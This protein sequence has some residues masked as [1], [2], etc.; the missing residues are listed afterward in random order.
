MTTDAT[1]VGRS[2]LIVLVGTGV[3]MLGF[4]LL[5]VV[6]AQALSR[7][8]FGAIILMLSLLDIA[9]IGC[10]FGLN[11]GLVKH[12]PAT[13]RGDHEQN[14]Y[15]TISFGIVGIT[16]ILLAG[17]GILFLEQ[18]RE[19]AFAGSVSSEFIILTL[20]ALP[21]Y[22]LIK[23]SAG[24]LQGYQESTLYTLVSKIALSGGRLIAAVGA[25]LL[26]GSG[27]AVV[28]GIL[29]AYVVT[30]AFGLALILWTGWRPE[31]DSD[32]AI[33]SF[34]SFS[35]PLLL[36]SSLYILLTTADKVMIGYFTSATATVGQYEVVVTIASLL[37]VFHSSFSF[38]LFPRIS[39]LVSNGRSNE[40]PSL[41]NQATRWI[42]IFT[43]PL[44]SVIL[45][46]PGVFV[47]LF[48]DEYTLGSL[49]MPIVILAGAKLVDSVLGPN[50]Q[51]LLGFGKS[52][53]IFIYNSI[54][55]GL[56]VI[57]NIV[58]IPRYGVI[59]AA[60]SSL[61][62]YI[63][64]NFLKTTDLYVNHQFGFFDRG[65]VLYSIVALITAT[66]TSTLIPDSTW[67]VSSILIVGI[68]ATTAL[69]GGLGALYF[70]GEVTN[71][72]RKTVK[73]IIGMFSK[74]W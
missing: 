34:F 68:I 6:L 43:V 9:V 39:E 21:F 2:G 48:G 73:S 64:M 40:I 71:E 16:S 65:A 62:G 19:A 1:D 45:L 67:I 22:A 20:I 66:I 12:L 74:V 28:A 47:D 41:Y 69:F 56:N 63:C 24:T 53:T 8:V 13:N 44:L 38:L 49:Y 26:V 61:V 52:R 55:V 7:D 27:I 3:S 10:L 18:V 11:Q 50:G 59:G 60:I 23:L 33:L 14:T 70:T 36:S 4:Y 58:L 30:A 46:R 29:V 31:F 25:L 51:A 54:A 72:D 5:R 32:A 42:L 17:I 57:L 35:F 37:T 15:I